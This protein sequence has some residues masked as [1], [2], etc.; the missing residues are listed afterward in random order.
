MQCPNYVKT[1]KVIKWDCAIQSSYTRVCIFFFCLFIM[2]KK[3]LFNNFKKFI[4]VHT[5]HVNFL[6][7]LRICSKVSGWVVRRRWTWGL[8]LHETICIKTWCTDIKAHWNFLGSVSC[9]LASWLYVYLYWF[10]AVSLEWALV[11]VFLN[12]SATFLPT[13][14]VYLGTLCLAGSFPLTT[15]TATSGT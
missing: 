10:C 14:S 8:N 1:I 7:C 12:G 13:S 11:R 2:M 5:T 4:S 3:V 15:S 6:F 9:L